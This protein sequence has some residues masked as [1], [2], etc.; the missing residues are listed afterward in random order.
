[1]KTLPIY[2]KRWLETN[3]RTRTLPGDTWYLN[4]ANETLPLLAA[5]SLFADKTADKITRTAL[6]TALYFQDAIAQTG[7]W[8]AF[9]TRHR[10]LYGQPLPF[11]AC[12]DYIDDEINRDDVCFRSMPATTTLT[13]KSTGTMS[14]SCYGRACPTFTLPS[15]SRTHTK[16]PCSYWPDSSTTVW[17]PSLRKRPSTMFP[18]R[19]HGS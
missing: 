1:M 18:H 17:T 12:N 9:T 4:F 2:M 5:S 14:V 15:T 16:K 6:N 10:M 13:T 19:R 3:G 7:G 8:K 11:Y